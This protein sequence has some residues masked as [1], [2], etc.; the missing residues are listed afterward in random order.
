M[1][2]I[3]F[4]GDSLTAGYGLNDPENESYPALIRQKINILN[5]P[6]RV[7]N[8]G[9]NGDTSSRGLRRLD[10]WLTE[11][12]S[13]FVLEL[14][15]NDFLRQIPPANTYVN[16]QAIIERVREKYPNAGMALMGMRLPPFIP[17]AA[18]EKFRSMYQ[19]LAEQYRMT[20][21]PFFLEGVAGKERLNL[22]DGLH[23]SSDGYKVIAD[24]VWPA[25]KSLVYKDMC[26]FVCSQKCELAEQSCF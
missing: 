20:F 26:R 2:N 14:G 25:L 10:N 17:G 18:A 13:L 4:F 8:A 16:L 22:G 12:I 19:K 7:I 11:P 6:Y 9:L 24:N 15:I 5:L 23:P 1:Q 3:L 21:V